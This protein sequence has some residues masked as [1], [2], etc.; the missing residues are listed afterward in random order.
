MSDF[1]EIFLENRCCSSES[2]VMASLNSLGVGRGSNSSGILISSRFFTIAE[3]FG[4]K[5][6]CAKI[7]PMTMMKLLNG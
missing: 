2:E 7:V 5:R 1:L 6:S 4:I 3:Y